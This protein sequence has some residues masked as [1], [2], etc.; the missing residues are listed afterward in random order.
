MDIPANATQA[1]IAFL[2]DKLAFMY[3]WFASRVP[4]VKVR[5]E[6]V[7]AEV[8]AELDFLYLTVDQEVSA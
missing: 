6:G 3:T 4:G 8:W 2:E 1:R 7:I 5:E